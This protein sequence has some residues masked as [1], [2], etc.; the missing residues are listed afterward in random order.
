MAAGAG[1]GEEEGEHDEAGQKEGAEE[2]EEGSREERQDMAVVLEADWG[3]EQ[4]PR[5]IDVGV[6]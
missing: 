3:M 5:R 1:A 6:A 4:T 2:A